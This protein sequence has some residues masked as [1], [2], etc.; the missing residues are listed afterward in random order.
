MQKFLILTTIL[1]LGGCANRY[2]DKPITA[3]SNEKNTDIWL[4]EEYQGS[5]YT[6]LRILNS[7]AKDA[8]VYGKKKGCETKKLKIEYTFDYS[9]LWLISP[10]QIYRF[11]TWDVW[12]VDED[13]NLYNVTPECS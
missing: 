7:K 1:A 10:S 6:Q 13:K 12:K 11:L 8:Y 4:D 9:V 2:P 5:E 3:M